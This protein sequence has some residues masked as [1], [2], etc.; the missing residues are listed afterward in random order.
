MADYIYYPNVEL[1]P[2]Q[3]AV[4]LES[5]GA[6]ANYVVSKMLYF[7]EQVRKGTVKENVE[8]CL[9]IIDTLNTE[10]LPKALGAFDT[11]FRELYEIDPTPE[12]DPEVEP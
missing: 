2:D 4:L 10:M 11:Y 5:D 8:E 12:P 7:I 3:E 1:D 9:S 6:Y